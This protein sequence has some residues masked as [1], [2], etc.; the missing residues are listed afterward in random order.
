M[1]RLAEAGA[2]FTQA[3]TTGPRTPSAFPPIMAS[4]YPL[5]SGERGIPGS[6]ETLAQAMQRS[7]RRTAG[8][9]P[10]NPY[11]S[12]YCGYHKGFDVFPGFVDGESSAR[13]RAGPAIWSRLK[14]GVQTRMEGHNLAVLLFAQALRKQSLTAAECGETLTRQALAWIGENGNRPFF[15]WLHYMD[16]H[17]PYLPQP[18]GY[19]AADVPSFLLA[20]ACSLLGAYRYPLRVMK[21]LYEQRVRDVDAMIGRI[22]AELRAMGVGDNTTIVVTSDHGEMFREHGAFTHG[23]EFYEELLRVP[24]I[25]SGPGIPTRTVVDTQ[26]PLLDLAPTILD[27]LSIECPDGFQGRSAMPLLRGERD[28]HRNHVFGEA[29]HRG[30]RRSR[31]NTDEKYRIISCRTEA[32]KYIWDEEDRKVELYS[33]ADDP[34]E[35]R[36]LANENPAE[37]A[38]FRALVEEHLAEIEKEAP[39]YD[40]ERIQ[41]SPE[42]NDE[43]NRRLAALG[44]L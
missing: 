31:K 24:L 37:A 22:A 6:A 43:I 23:P 40:G 14:K 35:R 7:G 42:D 10:A 30:G 34:L 18:D 12:D 17:Y 29:T 8:F 36:N 1:D 9:N 16:V 26:V 44:Y 25:I 11:L 38:R 20:F 5:V 13:R 15:A 2:L 41:C 33:L 4:L 28:T 21:R 19:R 32:W 39:K 27:M 3:G